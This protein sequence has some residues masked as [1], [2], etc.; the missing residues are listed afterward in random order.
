M[1]RASVEVT[2]ITDR[3]NKS[4]VRASGSGLAAARMIWTGKRIQAIAIGAIWSFLVAVCLWKL[5]AGTFNVARFSSDSAIPVLMANDRH[6][7]LFQSFYYGQDRFG[8]WPFLLIRIA[9]SAG[10]AVVRWEHVQLALAVWVLFGSLPF[11]RLF[12]AG[13][14]LAAFFYLLLVAMTP[15]L[16]ILF[17][18]HPYGWQL[19][20]VVLAWWLL[21][22]ALE[23]ESTTL[24]KSVFPR[25]LRWLAAF[26]FSA[27]ATWISPVSGPMLLGLGLLEAWRIRLV[28]PNSNWPLIGVKSVLPA[29]VAALFELALRH[30]YHVFALR[31]FGESYRT[32]AHADWDNLT[33][34]AKPLLQ[35]LIEFHWHLLLVLGAAGCLATTA[36]ILG[37][38]ARLRDA[39]DGPADRA[40]V[41]ASF[42][43]LGAAWCALIQVPILLASSHVRINEFDVRY[44]S[45]LFFFGS[46]A[47]LTAVA[48]AA[49]VIGGPQFARWSS[50]VA[51]IGMG[52]IAF[53]LP[54]P[55]EDPEYARQKHLAGQLARRAPGAVLLSD[56]WDT[57]ELSALEPRALLP[58]PF[59]GDYLRAPSYLPAL[60]G[61]REVIVGHY[62]GDHTP[63]LDPVLT[64]YGTKL[65]LVVRDW[66]GEYGRAYSL[67]TAVAP[68]TGPP[69][70]SRGEAP[71]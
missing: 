12:P 41:D 24:G 30:A 15:E 48:T 50:A 9:W 7:D 2:T 13:R 14:A 71:R 46:L 57:Y 66:Y 37:W 31:H 29:I 47:G 8:A 5:R 61:A 35:R 40:I 67:Y 32:S 36:L 69:A 26:L 68:L 34:K 55:V 3:T 45:L 1:N 19:T 33:A 42:M 44:F 28:A 18:L 56:Y 20:T 63:K 54:H 52:A 16:R 4:I 23:A 17:D 59:E 62:R 39:S 70:D 21:R 43:T 65:Y 6:W 25:V 51:A 60:R 38:R 64:Q 11:A 58:L 49:A 22:V 27:L 53:A 10:G